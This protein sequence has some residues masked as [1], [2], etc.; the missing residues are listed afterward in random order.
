M[1]LPPGAI[2]ADWP[3]P[4]GVHGFQSTRAGGTSVGAFGA[5]GGGGLNLAFGQD[6]PSCV[7]A[8]RARLRAFLPA[9][10]SWLAQ[11]HGTRVVDA[12][13]VDP[14]APPQAD[15]SWT[16]RPGVVC[17]VMVADCLPVLLCD[18]QGRGV[19]AIHAG[20]RGLAAGVLQQG[21]HALRA[22]IGDPGASLH[23][24]MGVAIGP[25]DFEVGPEVRAAMGAALPGA[26]QDFV[27]GR[28]D[29][30]LGDL[31]GLARR[32]LAQ[33]DVR[34]VHGGGAS[35]AADPARFYSHRRDAGRTGRQAAFAWMEAPRP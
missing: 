10:P 1:Q 21:A 7:Q 32:A 25:R 11:V 28:G 12:G 30:W 2:P 24:W 13:E 16:T 23:A 15:A 31:Y 8:N 6:D 9:E 5:P 14:G 17:V 33:A 20:W 22:A 4:P 19:A 18:A 34:S 3:A 29:R 27:A 35:T 26:E